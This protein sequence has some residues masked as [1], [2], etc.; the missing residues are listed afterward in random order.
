MAFGAGVPPVR[1]DGWREC[2][3]L[4]RQVLAAIAGYVR[5]PLDAER[6]RSSCRGGS[7]HDLGGTQ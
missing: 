7:R 1:A 2:I 4:I 5:L 6:P 3:H